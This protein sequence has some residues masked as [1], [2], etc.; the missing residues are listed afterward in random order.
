MTRDDVMV[1]G[2]GKRK[3]CIRIMEDGRYYISFLYD[4]DYDYEWKKG[5]HG[6]FCDICN[7]LQQAKG[8]AKRYINK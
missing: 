3:A 6:M 7:T 2:K 8:K 5:A 4:G 1:L